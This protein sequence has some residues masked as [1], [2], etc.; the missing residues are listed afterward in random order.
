MNSFSECP[1]EEDT[2]IHYNGTVT[3]LTRNQYTV[4]GELTFTEILN[5]PIEVFC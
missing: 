3:K 5:G 1:E 2:I 4:N